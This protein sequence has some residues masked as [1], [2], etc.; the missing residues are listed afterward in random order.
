VLDVLLYRYVSELTVPIREEVATQIADAW[1]R[2]DLDNGAN[3]AVHFLA[4]SLRS[5][6]PSTP[7][8]RPTAWLRRI[9]PSVTSSIP[10]P[11]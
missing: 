7:I 8:R 5:I 10:L 4:H 11:P 1:H 2:A 6:D 9:V 3:T